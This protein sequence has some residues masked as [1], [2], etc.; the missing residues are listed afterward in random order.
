MQKMPDVHSLGWEDP[1]EKEMATHSNILAWR[2]PWTEEPGGLQSMGSQRVRHNWAS[3]HCCSLK[4]LNCVWWLKVWAREAGRPVREENPQSKWPSLREC[5]FFIYIY[6]CLFVFFGYAGSWFPYSK[7]SVSVAMWR[8]FN[9]SMW[10]VSCGLCSLVP[11]PGTEHRPPALGV[12]R[13]SHWTTREV[14]LESVVSW[15]PLYLSL[16]SLFSGQL[17]RCPSWEEPP[18]RQAGRFTS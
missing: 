7:S 6:I 5:F 14:P 2:I 12:W 1:L 17:K 9:C 16:T 18:D 13:F 8:I 15:R 4:G 10:T 11:W 3:Q